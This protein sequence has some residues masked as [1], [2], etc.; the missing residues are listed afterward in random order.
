MGGGPS[1]KSVMAVMQTAVTRMLVRKITYLVHFVV[2]LRIVL[3]NLF[4]LLEIKVPT[5]KHEF[6]RQIT[7][8]WHQQA[9]QVTRN[10][11]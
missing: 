3:V 9:R 4:L 6:S 7:D 5:F 10:F 11:V 2:V 8:S 1:E